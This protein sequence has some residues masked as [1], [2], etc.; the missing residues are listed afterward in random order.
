M[1]KRD[2]VFLLVSGRLGQHCALY[3]NI[4]F[5]RAL[6][7]V[8]VR[9]VVR[10]I[11]VDHVARRVHADRVK[12]VDMSTEQRSLECVDSFPAPVPHEVLENFRPQPKVCVGQVVC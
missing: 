1:T 9:L 4:T 10:L 2:A 7:V 12:V 6:P 5:S 3:D 11:R 8:T